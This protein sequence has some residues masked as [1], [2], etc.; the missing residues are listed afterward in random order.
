MY[1]H[2]QATIP[3]KLGMRVDCM[4]TEGCLWLMYWTADQR[5]NV[6]VPLAT[7]ISSF[8]GTQPCLKK[9]SKIFTFTSFG[10]DVKPLVQ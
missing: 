4:E 5:S 10:G 8:G 3:N 9:L 2:S 7:E 6:P 1:S